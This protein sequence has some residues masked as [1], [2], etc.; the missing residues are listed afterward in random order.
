VSWGCGFDNR[1]EQLAGQCFGFFPEEQ[2]RGAGFDGAQPRPQLLIEKARLDVQKCDCVL[3]RQAE[4]NQLHQ[5][6]WGRFAGFH[7]RTFM[8]N[9]SRV[10]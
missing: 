3:A 4:R 1:V 5:G 6:A 10:T 9:I 2:Q 8:G 7:S